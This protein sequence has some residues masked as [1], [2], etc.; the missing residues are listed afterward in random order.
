MNLLNLP[1]SIQAGLEA[2]V[3][4]KFRVELGKAVEAVKELSQAPVW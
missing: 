3:D 2:G 1:Q 4:D